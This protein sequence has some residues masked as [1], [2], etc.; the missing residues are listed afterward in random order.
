M[1][2][3]S[4]E[5][6]LEAILIA[7]IENGDARGYFIADFLN[8]S[9]PAVTKCLNQLKLKGYLEDNK[10]IILSP[11][12]RAI[13]ESIYEKHLKCKE[14]LMKIGVS[15]DVAKV[16]CCKIEHCISEETFEKIKDFCSKN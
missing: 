3:K 1:V 5:D 14:F 13:A 4:D 9:R 2:S 12:G 8:V 7:E 15:E 10:K 16:D 6:Y 11:A